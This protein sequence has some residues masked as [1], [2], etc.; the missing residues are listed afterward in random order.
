MPKSP[1]RR[2]LIGREQSEHVSIEWIG[3]SQ[4]GWSSCTVTVRCDGWSG[5][6]RW[7][8]Y[9]DE[10]Q[11]F[12]DELDE[13]YRT[14]SGRAELNPLEPNLELTAIGDGKGHIMIRGKAIAHLESDTHLVFGFGLDQTDIPP[15]VKSLRGA[16]HF[17]I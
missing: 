4:E 16:D 3:T 12:A 9:Q 10:L 1:S 13:L 5:A 14:L 7:D 11:R 6:F 17:G 2:I 15:I 8:C